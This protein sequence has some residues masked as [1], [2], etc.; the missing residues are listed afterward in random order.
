[1]TIIFPGSGDGLASVFRGIEYKGVWTATGQTNYSAIPLPV[2]KG[3]MFL[4]DGSATI[5]GIDWSSG[6]YLIVDE[7]VA[8]GGTLTD[9]YKFSGLNAADIVKLNLVQTLTNKTIDADDNTIKDLTVANLKSGVLQTTVRDTSTALNTTIASEKAIATALATKTG[10][11]L[12]S[13]T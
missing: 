3:D 13:W 6:D 4:V 12:R 5:G 11:T 7:D 2:S 9:V 1:M 8:V 10:I